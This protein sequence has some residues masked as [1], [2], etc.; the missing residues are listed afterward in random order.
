MALSANS[1]VTK[2]FGIGYTSGAA[3]L[4]LTQKTASSDSTSVTVTG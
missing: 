4:T 1:S 2:A 3:S